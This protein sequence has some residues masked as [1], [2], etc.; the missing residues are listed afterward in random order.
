MGLIGRPDSRGSDNLAGDKSESIDVSESIVFRT[1]S[2]SSSETQPR[3][4]LKLSKFEADGTKKVSRLKRLLTRST[5]SLRQKASPSD[6]GSSLP[7]GSPSVHSRGNQE[8]KLPSFRVLRGRKLEPTVEEVSERRYISFVESGAPLVPG[9]NP[10]GFNS[11]NAT[12]RLAQGPEA[13][14]L[15]GGPHGQSGYEESFLIQHFPPDRPEQELDNAEYDLLRGGYAP[16]DSHDF[17][18]NEARRAAA[19]GKALNVRHGQN[20]RRANVQSE[21]PRPKEPPSVLA[22][23]LNSFGD[24]YSAYVP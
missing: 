2:I 14:V 17:A 10:H 16:Q 6:L 11:V 20:S 5:T 19:I 1:P 23:M 3:T 21:A 4:S 9:L 22:K 24:G 12:Q 7:P 15:G 13:N 8:E 18:R